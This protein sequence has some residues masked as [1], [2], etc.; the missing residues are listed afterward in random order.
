MTA[1]AQTGEIAARPAARTR[2]ADRTSEERG[3]TSSSAPTCRSSDTWCAKCWPA[4]P[5]T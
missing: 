5:P 1:I 3:R 2:T 4:S